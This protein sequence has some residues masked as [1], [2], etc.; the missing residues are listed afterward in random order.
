M[1]LTKTSLQ[2]I[3]QN[4]KNIKNTVQGKTKLCT[5]SYSFSI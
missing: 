2:S 5:I 3:E 4:V 1:D